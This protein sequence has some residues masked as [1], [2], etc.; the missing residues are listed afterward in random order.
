MYIFRAYQ[1]PASGTHC[2]L[3]CAHMPNF[4]SRY[5]SGVSYCSRESHVGWYGPVPARLGMEVVMGTPSHDPPGMGSSGGLPPSVGSHVAS[6]SFSVTILP[7]TSA[8]N[9]L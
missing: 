8:W 7:S 6:S 4:A 2:G 3:Q 1:S 5:H 9:V